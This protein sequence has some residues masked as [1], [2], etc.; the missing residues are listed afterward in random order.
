V[1]KKTI[2]ELNLED[3]QNDYAGKFTDPFVTMFSENKNVGLID[4]INAIENA[5]QMMISKEFYFKQY[6]RTGNGTVKPYAMLWKVLKNQENSS[7]RMPIVF[8]KEY[9]LN[10]VASPIYINP[11]GDGF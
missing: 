6:I 5:K 10:S 3:I 8:T 2:L 9:Y 7:W 4:I 1:V 11:V